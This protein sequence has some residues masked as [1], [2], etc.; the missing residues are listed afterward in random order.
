MHHKKKISDFL[1]DQKIPVSQK[2]S[3]TVLESDG[4]IIWV[5]GMRVDDR[6]KINEGTRNVLNL[7]LSV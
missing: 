2:D 5:V 4:E 7:F 3:V 1:I 6:F